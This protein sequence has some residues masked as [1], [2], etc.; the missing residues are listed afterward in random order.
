MEEVEPAVVMAV[1]GVF[2]VTI[3][4]EFVDGMIM[5]VVAKVTA[6]LLVVP[7]VVVVFGAAVTVVP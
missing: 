5:V 1:V 3:V 2:S 7:A 6:V 4:V